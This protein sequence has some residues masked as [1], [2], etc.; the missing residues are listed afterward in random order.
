MRNDAIPSGEVH[1]E[2]VALDLE[3]G[4]CFGMDRI[5]SAIWKLADRP[6]AVGALADRLSETHAV[7]REQCLADILPFLEQL[8]GEDLLRVVA[9]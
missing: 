9:E 2:L 4:H 6:I 3:R 5:G 7:E 1:G 8:L